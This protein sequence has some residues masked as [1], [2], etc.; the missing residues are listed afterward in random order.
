MSKDVRAKAVNS[1]RGE[2]IT[3]CLYELHKIK[4]TRSSY[5]SMLFSAIGIVGLSVV[6]CSI[7]NARSAHLSLSQLAT[8]DPVFLALSGT[9][10][11]QLGVVVFSV[12]S[13][14][15]EYGY[16][17]IVTSLLLEPKRIRFAIAKITVVTCVV[18]FSSLIS[19]SVAFVLG[20]M[21]LAPKFAVVSV[22][23]FVALKAIVGTAFYLSALATICVGLSFVIRRTSGAIASVFAILLV[24]PPIISLLPSPWNVDIIRYLPS[25]AGVVL[26][27]SLHLTNEM[28]PMGSFL[29]MLL[30]SLISFAGGL[31]FIDRRDI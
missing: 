30:Y 4:S 12:L 18:F 19:L 27:H 29:L 8:T 31:Y 5:V 28:T 10:L 23:S 14:A 24:L 20:E 21:I 1:V 2:Y 16:G 26:A 25:S 11:A 22:I 15:N 13:V 6:V 3:A 9:L 17:T 7:Y